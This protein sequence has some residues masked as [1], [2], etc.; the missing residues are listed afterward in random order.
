MRLADLPEVRALSP[1][2]KLEL[3]EELWQEAARDLEGFG[4]SSHEEQLL[5]QRWAAFLLDPSSALTLEQLQEKVKAL[6]R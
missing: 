4:V 5:D 6:R 3:V 2:E 1:Q